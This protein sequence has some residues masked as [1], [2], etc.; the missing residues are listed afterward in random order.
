MT[1][2]QTIEGDSR[3]SIVIAITFYSPSW[4]GQETG[5]GTFRPSSQTAPAQ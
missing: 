3:R 1:F 5:E 2:L 4:L